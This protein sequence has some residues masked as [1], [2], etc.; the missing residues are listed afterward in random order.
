MGGSPG[1]REGERRGVNRLGGR[2]IEWDHV[3]ALLAREAA[4][5]MGRERALTLEPLTDPDAVRRALKETRQGRQALALAGPPPWGVLP[6]VR[7]SL[8]AARTP[9]ASLEGTELVALIPWLD[10]AGRLRAY[11]KRVASVAPDL[12]ESLTRLPVFTPLHTLLTRS[13]AEDGTLTDEASPKLRRI[14]Q[15]IRD[16]RREIVEALEALLRVQDAESP[17]QDRYVT[18][19]HGRYV[20]PVRFEAKSRVRGIVHDRSQSGAT[21]FLE[22][23]RVVELNNELVQSIREED[24]ETARILLALTDEVRARLPE[25]EMLVDAIGKA[26]LIFA[27]AGLAERMAA[28][29]PEI[30]ADK[31]VC[32]REARHPL[33]L[34]QSWTAPEQPVVAVDLLLDRAR[35]ILVVTGPNAGGKTVALKTL[36]LLALMA[37]AGCH[38]PVKEGSR[39]P[40]FSQFFA[41]VGDDQ[42]VAENLSTFSAFVRQVSDILRNVN[43]HSLVL[44]D[45][46]G[47]GTDPEE[48][49]ALAQAILET[50]QDQGALV[51]ATTHLEPLKGFGS[52]HPGARNASVEFDATRLTPTFRLIY[53]QPGQSYALAIG[54]RLGLPPSLIERA[55]SHRSTQARSLQDLLARLEGQAHEGEVRME[56]G[57]RL[58]I[59]AATLRAQAQAELE[60]ARLKAQE[61]KAKAR[62]EAETL[63]AE[64]SRAIAE[65]RERLKNMH[66]L[67]SLDE[68][69]RRMREVASALRNDETREELGTRA[70]DQAPEV[71]DQVEVT[72][73]GL[74]GELLARDGS[75][76][77]VRAGSATVRVQLQALRV[78]KPMGAGVADLPSQGISA[79]RGRVIN[80]LDKSGIPSELHLLGRTTDEARDLVE[81]YLDDAFLAGLASIRLIHGKGTGALRK[82]IHELLAVHPLVLSFRPGEPREGGGGATMVELRV[83]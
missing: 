69:R 57:N 9:G 13:L 12:Q 72:D 35:P 83:D 52:V 76:A 70:R 3:R 32:L 60:G 74:R 63:L 64:V 20:L 4:T 37:Q 58:M 24:A 7:P 77:T 14:R 67:K 28:T 38:L 51:M 43:V 68:S 48:G 30:D 80:A 54:A 2:G 17:Y 10:S 11:G 25:I 49:A 44:L 45:E 42:S 50:L 15:K 5:L 47:A 21:L 18:L 82:S 59:E 39:L 40:I 46:L 71:G 56:T 26:D 41:V 78:I 65:E 36:G 61:T 81:K 55:Q 75:T 31:T 27:R 29:E 23:E 16:L 6:D 1:T 22:P 66:S 79:M 19:R 8:E 34:A 53:D 73:L 62:S 33:L